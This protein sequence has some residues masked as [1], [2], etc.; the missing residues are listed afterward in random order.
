MSL[1]TKIE[2][3]IENAIK[4]V[5]NEVKKVFVHEEKPKASIVEQSPVKAVVESKVVSP[6][7][8]PAPAVTEP[9]SKS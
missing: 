2:E 9:V 5:E 7:V 6:G 8:V 3:K 1:M 4:A